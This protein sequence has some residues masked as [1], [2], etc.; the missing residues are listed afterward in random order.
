MLGKTLLS[1][2]EKDVLLDWHRH[3]QVDPAEMW[4]R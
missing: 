3:R 1:G 4:L 2:S